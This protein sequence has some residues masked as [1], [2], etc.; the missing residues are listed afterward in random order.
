MVTRG[1]AAVRMTRDVG[2]PTSPFP[3]VSRP[4]AYRTAFAVSAL[5]NP[6]VTTRAA[7]ATW[8]VGSSI[9]ETS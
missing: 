3:L 7:M 5:L 8:A 2:I 9:L 1:P 6:S 4:A